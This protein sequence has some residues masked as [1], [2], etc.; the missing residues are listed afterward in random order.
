MS[1]TAMVVIGLILLALVVAAIWLHMQRQT[2]HLRD[3]FGPEYQRAVEEA[4]GGHSAESEL[5]AR[6]ARCESS[7][8]VCC[9]RDKSPASP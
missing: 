9:R 3:Q 4:G 5:R 1:T 8:V 7:V 2:Q 6:E